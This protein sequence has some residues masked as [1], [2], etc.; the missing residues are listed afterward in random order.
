E[1][2][3]EVEI[4]A[5]GDTVKPAPRSTAWPLPQT[6]W[7]LFFLDAANRTLGPDRPHDMPSATY[8][9]L[10]QRVP[11]S[12]AP[13]SHNAEIA[14]PVTAQL[15]VSWSTRDMDIFATVCAFDPHG[16]EMTFIAAP[17]TKSPVTQ[18][19]L[20]VSQRK[21]HPQRST[22][23]LPYYPHDERQPLE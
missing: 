7:T 14:G 17:E 3:G 16:Q 23:Y 2:P 4:R 5:P 11:F 21:L 1:P 22:E 10:S 12:T 20:R 8:S 13:W 6:Q 18:G 9:A 15:F 19:W